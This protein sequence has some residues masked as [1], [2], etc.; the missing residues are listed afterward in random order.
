MIINCA[1]CGKAVKVSPSR[2]KLHNFCSRACFAQYFGGKPQTCPVCGKEFCVEKSRSQKY[3]SRACFVKDHYGH[4]PLPSEEKKI[5]DCYIKEA[6]AMM[7]GKHWEGKNLCVKLLGDEDYVPPPAPLPPTIDLPRP[8]SLPIIT[9]KKLLARKRVLTQR[10]V[11]RQREVL[12][13]VV[14]CWQSIKEARPDGDYAWSE[15]LIAALNEA[16]E[17]LEPREESPSVEDGRTFK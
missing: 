7:E 1:N 17:F 13:F 6:K 8:K 2:K 3:C 16:E 15:E 11:L 10:K 4:D 14:D 9:G 12:K 5:A